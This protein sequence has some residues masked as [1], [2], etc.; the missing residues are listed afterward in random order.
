MGKRKKDVLIAV[1]V[2]LVLLLLPAG[3]VYYRL[4][5][6]ANYNIGAE[7]PIWTYV[8][9]GATWESISDSLDAAME[10]R[11]HGDLRLYSRLRPNA[12]PKV[13]AYLIR[14]NSTTREVY[15]LISYGLQT[16]VNL[17]FTSS[18]NKGAIWQSISRQLMLDSASIAQAMSDSALLNKL[19][20]KDTTA[21]YHILPNTY[22]VYWTITGEE[23]VTRLVKEYRLFWNG[24]RLASAK[25][26][27]LT[28]Y[29]VMILASIVQEESIR[30][31]EYPMIAGLYLNRL[32]R[33]MPLQADPTV[34]YA[35]GD[36]S[37]RRLLKNHLTID[38]PYNTYRTT[39]LPPGPIRIP[40]IQAIDGV[41]NAVSH[42]YIYMCARSDFSGYHAFAESYS[43]HLRN[44]RL[45]QQELNKRKIY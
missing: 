22:E 4:F 12:F 15:N 29:E 1:F 43:E 27:G 16:P 41:L 39:G 24:D 20:V 37:I 2:V 11:H 31:D 25:S 19:E 10:A 42:H 6:E 34:K 33:G 17:T 14:P 44:A 23:L 26:L 32:K 13:G 7:K 38:S 5:Q 3:Y 28:Q 40:S 8:Y 30:V 45:Y 9:P 36:S 21:L 35:L 18:R